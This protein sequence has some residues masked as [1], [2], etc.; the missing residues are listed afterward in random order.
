MTETPVT[1]DGRTLRL[2]NLDKVLYPE[3]GFTKAHVLD[4]YAAVADVLLPR[5]AGRPVT[6]RRYPEGVGHTGFF[7][8]NVSR[9]APDWVSTARLPTPH[10]ERGTSH[11]DY[12]LIPDRPSLMWVANLAG[13]ELHVPQWPVGD[14]GGRGNPDL[15]VFDLDPGQGASIVHCCRVA[16][17]IRELLAADGLR[18]WPKTSGSKGLQLY[19]PVTVAEPERTVDYA[20]W[21]AARLSREHPE[22]VVATMSRAARAGKVFV[23]WNQNKQAKTTI[24]AYSLRAR[25]RPTVSTPVSWEEVAECRDTEDL[26]FTVGDVRDR[27]GEHGDLFGGLDAERYEIPAVED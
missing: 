7:E 12:V 5:L 23:D 10:S 24:A 4:Y 2:T 3:T 16:G 15:L 8:K 27:L 18:A 20:R 22:S 6:L 1:V 14:D 25:P 21:V 19:V 13:I 11:A 17:W 26:V 9:H